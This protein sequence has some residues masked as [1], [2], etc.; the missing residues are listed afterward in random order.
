MG[1]PEMQSDL[2]TFARERDWE[3]FHSTKNLVMALTGEVG[4]LNA[5][6]QWV[7]ADNI[8]EWMTVPANREAAR[9][10]IADVLAY[11]LQLAD[12]LGIEVEE[13]FNAKLG[14]NAEKYP[15]ERAKG[16]ATKYNALG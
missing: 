5:L 10:E 14:K 2:R 16:V 12:G 8:Q 13:A 6:L 15:V 7:E 9:D 11:L 1:I 4:E 3:Q